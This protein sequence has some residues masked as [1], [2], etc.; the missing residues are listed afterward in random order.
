MSSNYCQY[1][2]L[3]YSYQNRT[4]A[5]NHANIITDKK[6]KRM[7]TKA[8]MPTTK[9]AQLNYYEQKI[10]TNVYYKA[11]NETKENKLNHAGC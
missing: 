5:C 11:G 6:I 4:E 3:A 2:S 10:P 7:A 1:D 9:S 8:V